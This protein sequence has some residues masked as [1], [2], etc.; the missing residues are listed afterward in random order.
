MTG[1]GTQRGVGM[2]PVEILFVDTDVVACDG[3]GDA[4]GHPR[5][6]LHMTD[7]GEVTCP[8]CGRRYIQEEKAAAGGG[9]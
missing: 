6:Y 8:Y 7:A 1:A 2:E 4:L 3:G 9:H 5:V